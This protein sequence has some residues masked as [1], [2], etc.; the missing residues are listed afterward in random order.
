MQGY[1]RFIVL[2]GM[3]GSGKGTQIKFLSAYF[4]KHAIPHHFTREPGGSPDAEKIRERIFS[5][6][7]MSTEERFALMWES[8]S[9]HI[10]QTILPTLTEGK[11]VVSDRF[12]SSTWAY[13]IRGEKNNQLI[14]PFETLRQH[15]VEPVCSPALYIFFNLDPALSRARVLDAAKADQNYLDTKPVEF[16]ERVCMGFQEFAQKYPAVVLDAS[17]SPERVFED[18]LFVLK[19]KKIL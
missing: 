13:Q 4:A 12:D 17:Q 3:D 18:L 16:Y 19:D 5:D 11:L 10:Q 14:E 6:E 7:T 9:L 2:D 1:N 8:R 15:M